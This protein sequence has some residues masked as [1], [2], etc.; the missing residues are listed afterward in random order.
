MPAKDFL[1]KSCFLA[2]LCCYHKGKAINEEKGGKA[3]IRMPF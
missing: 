1:H 2:F 3:K